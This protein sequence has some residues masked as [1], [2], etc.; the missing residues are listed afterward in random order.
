M[1]ELADKIEAMKSNGHLRFS[2]SNGV[3]WVTSFDEPTLRT[4]CDIY[5]NRS[6]VAEALRSPAQQERPLS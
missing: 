3:G 4:L 5:N 6:E 2:I 1:N